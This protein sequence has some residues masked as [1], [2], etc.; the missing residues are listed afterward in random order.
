MGSARFTPMPFVQNPMGMFETIEH[1]YVKTSKRQNVK[2]TI[3]TI[4]ALTF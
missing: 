2:A 4:V 3:T 1:T